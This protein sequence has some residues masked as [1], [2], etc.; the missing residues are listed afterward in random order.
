M[1]INRNRMALVALLAAALQGCSTTPRFNDQFGASVRANLSAQ[2]LDPAAAANTDPAIG[3]E[4]AVAA[5][6]HERYLHSFKE[7]DAG[8][9]K[10]LVG[11]EVGGK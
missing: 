5:A 6:A 7:A 3:T 8:A 4:G 11:G 9:S 2:V 1:S 10:P